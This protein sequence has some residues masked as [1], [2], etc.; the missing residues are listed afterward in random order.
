MSQR[1][2]PRALT[3]SNDGYEETCKDQKVFLCTAKCCGTTA[4]FAL[5]LRLYEHH[6]NEE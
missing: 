5:Q 2:G 1:L 4:V 3:A 6:I